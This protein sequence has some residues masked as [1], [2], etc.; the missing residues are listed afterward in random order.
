MYAYTLG[1]AHMHSYRHIFSGHV[2]AM[3]HHL[4]LSEPFIIDSF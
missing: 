3:F 2:L 4:F 1:E